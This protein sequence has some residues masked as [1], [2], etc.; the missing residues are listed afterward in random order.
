M[1]RIQY[2]D[3][4]LAP[5]DIVPLLEEA[6]PDDRRRHHDRVH[7]SATGRARATRAASAAPHYNAWQYRVLRDI[8][9][10]ELGTLARDYVGS[11]FSW[12]LLAPAPRRPEL[13][14]VGRQTDG[15][16]HRD[17]GRDRRAGD[18]RGRLPSCAPPSAAP[19]A[20]RGDASIPR[21][22]ARPRWA[23][24]GIGPLE[25]YFNEG[26]RAVP[27][28]AGAVNNT[29][30]RYSSAYPDPTDPDYRP[31]RHRPVFDMTNMPSYRLT[32][33]MHDLDGARLIITTGQ[34]GQPVRSPLQRPDRAV[35]RR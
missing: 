23:R 5:R 22:S 16:R 26:P 13:G 8:F 32:I 14:V 25:W 20:G 34:S 17:L 3:S 31:G 21:P 7:G 11:P 28:T 33:D 19:T 15:G 27:G 24:S 12:V 29:Y 10:D 1:R 4:P 30:F 9:D 35:D 6:T 2:D 18:G